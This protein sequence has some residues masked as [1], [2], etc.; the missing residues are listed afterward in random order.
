MAKASRLYN[1]IIG[2]VHVSR[3]VTYQEDKC[4]P[5]ENQ[6]TVK[7][8]VKFPGSLVLVN[9]ESAEVDGAESGNGSQ[10]NTTVRSSISSGDESQP[11]TPVQSCTL[12]E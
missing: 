11:N 4:W 6:S 9:S 12:G 2:H 10:T 7:N 1:P 3:D 5:L 8:E